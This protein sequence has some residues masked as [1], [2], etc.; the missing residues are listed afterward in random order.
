MDGEHIKNR[1]M[2]AMQPNDAPPNVKVQVV[3]P[4]NDYKK[5]SKKRDN[6]YGQSIYNRNVWDNLI[7]VVLWTTA[8]ATCVR[9]LTRL[10]PVISSGFILITLPIITVLGFVW[11]IANPRQSPFKRLLMLAAI[12]ASLINAYE[13]NKGGDFDGA[14]QSTGAIHMG[15]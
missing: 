5:L 6:F 4:C 8:P 10:L 7:S 12:T 14:I 9:L 1:V 11:I 15:K 3:D 2:E 13:I